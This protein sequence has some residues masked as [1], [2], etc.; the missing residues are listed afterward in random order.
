MSFYIQRDGQPQQYSIE[1]LS[2]M[3]K[4][5]Q[6]RADEYVF[7]G[8]TQQWVGATQVAELADAW[9]TAQ[10]G[11]TPNIAA[12]KPG[13]KKRSSKKFSETSWFMSAVTYE[14][15]GLTPSELPQMEVGDKYENLPPVPDEL[16]KKYSLS[17]ADLDEKK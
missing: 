14:E 3:V 8:R 16:R 6:L 1:A 13:A 15:G 10:G 7:D 9:K 17:I 12:A 11:G 5:G 2:E 4:N